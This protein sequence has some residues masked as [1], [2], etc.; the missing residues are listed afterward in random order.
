M[1]IIWTAHFYNEDNL[2][3]FC[4]LRTCI[5]WHCGI[6]TKYFLT[7]KLQCWFCKTWEKQKFSFIRFCYNFFSMSLVIIFFKQWMSVGQV[8]FWMT[9]KQFKSKSSLNGIYII[10]KLKFRF[11]LRGYLK[12]WFCSCQNLQKRFVF[13]FLLCENNLKCLRG[14]LNVIWNNFHQKS[15]RSNV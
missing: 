12:F 9:K 2:S 10:L 4:L 1:N 8:S 15:I 6:H 11:R 5:E 13:S 14:R 3:Q 7:Q